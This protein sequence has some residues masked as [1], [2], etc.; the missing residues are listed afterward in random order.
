MLTIDHSS[1]TELE[2]QVRRLY[3][4]DRYGVSGLAEAGY[5]ETHPIIAA[6]M[7]VSYI[8]ARGLH[9]EETQYDE[10]LVKYENIFSYPEEYDTKTEVQNYIDELT[11]IVDIYL[12]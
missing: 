9:S 10:F 5:F 11:K 3:Q 7:I 4:C 1:A 6:I 8:H 12:K 2:Y